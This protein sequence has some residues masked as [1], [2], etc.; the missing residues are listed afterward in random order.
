MTSAEVEGIAGASSL[1]VFDGAD[2]RW[3]LPVAAVAAVEKLGDWRGAPPLDALGLLGDVA[4]RSATDERK[5][6]VLRHGKRQLPLLVCGHIS[7]VQSTPEALLDLP[8]ALRRCAPL[9]AQ[10]ALVAGKPRLFV[11]A[12]ERFFQFEHDASAEGE[13]QGPFC[14]LDSR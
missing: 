11:L 10:I 13:P 14:D 3:A 7:L 6:L 5:V 12:P 1:L 4:V 2:H 8:K 9:V